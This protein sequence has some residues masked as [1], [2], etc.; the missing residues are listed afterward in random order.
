MPLDH[1]GVAIGASHHFEREEP[2]SFGQWYHGFLHLTLPSG[3][4]ECALDVDTP[5]G[6]GI[7]FR[8]V[9]DAS[10][11]DLGSV[12]ALADGW[13]ELPRTSTSGAIDYVRTPWLQDRCV[14]TR[15]RRF[16]HR[17]TFARMGGPDGMPGGPEDPFIPDWIDSML[18]LKE[19]FAGKLGRWP[20]RLPFLKRRSYPWQVSTGDN[21]L[22]ALEAMLPQATKI[23]V[24][25]Q[26]YSS[27]Q[28]VHNVHMNQGD[29]PNTQWWAKNATWQDGVVVLRRSDDRLV[30]WQVKFGN[31]SLTTDEDGHPV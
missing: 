11:S 2:D 12:A 26:R 13:H 8:I 10:V 16:K 23:Y 28:G 17:R 31:Q 29:P 20:Q 30:A 22:S 19:W 25:G 7:A 9:D 3:Q 1:T 6:Q 15:L 18:E 4:W 27:G 14:V 24:F 5:G 21:A